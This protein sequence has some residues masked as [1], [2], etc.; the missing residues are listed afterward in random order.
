LPSAEISATR[1]STETVALE[2]VW[3]AGSTKTLGRGVA[4]GGGVS[5]AVAIAVNA[6]VAVAVPIAVAD[7][8]PVG[9]GVDTSVALAVAGGTIVGAAVAI[10]VAS[11]VGVAESAVAVG[12]G[13]LIAVAAVVAVALTIGV[14]GRVV[15]VGVSVLGGVSV[16]VGEM[17]VIEPFAVVGAT[18][19]PAVSAKVTRAS[20]SSDLPAATVPNLRAVRT[21]RPLGPGPSPAVLQPNV[22]L[23][24]AAASASKRGAEQ[25]TVR[26]VEPRNRS[27]STLMN[28]RSEGSHISVK[29]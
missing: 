6:G 11:A 19:R 7:G 16:T 13:V 27:F 18:G 14:A 3:A 15:A 9:S 29:S 21:P 26:P 4:V 10:V 23:P 20:I 2:V 28:V 5:T 17:I 24:G 22:T 1:M 8:V 25:T 12:S